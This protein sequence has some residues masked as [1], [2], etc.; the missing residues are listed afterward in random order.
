MHVLARFGLLLVLVSLLVC[1]ANAQALTVNRIAGIGVSGFSGDGG[2]SIAALLA[3]PSGVAV[4]AA[5][6]IYI[7]DTANNRIRKISVGGTITTIVGTG[8]AGFSGDGDVATAAQ[9]N[10]P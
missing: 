3:G 2:P 6:N 10:T 5:G 8:T 7:A 4:D 9:L 1:S